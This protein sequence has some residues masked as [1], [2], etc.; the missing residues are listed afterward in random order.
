MTLLSAVESLSLMELPAVS[1]IYIIPFRTH[2]RAFFTIA[3]LLP[4][5]RT[6]LPDEFRGGT[7]RFWP[8]QSR[9]LEG[10]LPIQDQI[11]ELHRSGSLGNLSQVYLRP[12]K[13]ESRGVWIIETHCGTESERLNW[14]A[15]VIAVEGRSPW[16]ESLR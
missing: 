4:F 15:S 14:M 8:D 11:T 12:T 9:I 10:D 6:D 3:F 1:F 2:Y 5:S 13:T 7:L 16:R